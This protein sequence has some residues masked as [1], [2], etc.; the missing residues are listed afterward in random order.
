MGRILVSA[1]H[2]D[3]LCREAWRILEENGHEVIFDAARSFPAYSLKELKEILK[4]IDAAIIGLD[5]YTKEVFEHAPRLKAV[6]KFGVGVD[7]IDIEA[8]ARHG[9]KVLN[10]PGRNANAVAELTV[11]FM[12]DLIRRIGPLHRMTSQGQWPRYMGTEIQ[13]KKIGLLGFG[14]I[15]KLVAE[16]LQGFHTKVYAYD[17]YPDYQ[18]AEKLGV[19][20]TSLNEIIENCD[21]ISLH[22]PLSKETYHMFN[23]ELIER[24]KTGSYLIN[25]ARGALVDL[26][27]L[28]RGLKSGKIAGAAL[29]AFEKEPVSKEEPVLSCEN[30]I[31]TPHTGGETYESYRDISICTAEDIVRV[32]NGQKPVYWVNRSLF[33]E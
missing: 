15:A 1:S 17:I 31:V 14:A 22:I 23:D 6:A 12:I 20:M 4:D 3:T 7:N 13:S 5:E 28:A 11:G 10:A 16:K 29:D 33:L 18:Y 19:T 27:A 25:A 8:A 30:L 26:E 24:M 9:V 32:L 2:Y 21:I